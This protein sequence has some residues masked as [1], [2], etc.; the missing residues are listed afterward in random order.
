ME[1]KLAFS[2]KDVWVTEVMI[3]CGKTVAVMPWSK[4]VSSSVCLDYIR[5]VNDTTVLYC[6]QYVQY[7]SHSNVQYYTVMSNIIMAQNSYLLY[8]YF[9]TCFH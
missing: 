7:C 9:L 1:W 8:I 3:E 4:I 2:E 5:K 6:K